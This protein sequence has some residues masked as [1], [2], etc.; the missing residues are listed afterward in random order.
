M[1]LQLVVELNMACK[2]FDI[3]KFLKVAHI[4]KEVR[5]IYGTYMQYTISPV[6]TNM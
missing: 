2:F 4:L 3:L 1:T 5:P 6:K